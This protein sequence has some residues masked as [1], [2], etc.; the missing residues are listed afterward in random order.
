MDRQIINKRIVGIQSEI[1]KLVRTLCVMENTDISRYPENYE[2]LSTD[3]ALRAEL[4]T[5]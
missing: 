5:C 2:M 1:E 4:I 3:A